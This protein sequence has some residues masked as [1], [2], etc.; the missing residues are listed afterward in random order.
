VAGALLRLHY[1]E[2]PRPG[3]LWRDLEF[4][5]D[6]QGRFRVECLL[7][8]QEH[9]L[10]V[11]GDAKRAITPA[12]PEKPIKLS[13]AAGMVRDLGDIRVKVVPVKEG[14]SKRFPPT[15]FRWGLSW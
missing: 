11:A 9:G 4:R 13:V 1:P 5:T 8:R 7:P 2:L 3:L 6:P 12:A 10:S 15:W 14:A